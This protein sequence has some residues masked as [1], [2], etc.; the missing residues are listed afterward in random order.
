LTKRF[1]K[2]EHCDAN[3]A[4]ILTTGKGKNTTMELVGKA[5]LRSDISKYSGTKRGVERWIKIVE[6]A[7]WSHIEE[8]KKT[9]PSLISKA[10]ITESLQRLI[11]LLSEFT[12][13][14]FCLMQNIPSANYRIV[15]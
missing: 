4:K 5:K 7:E 15:N 8:V 13:S 11:T 3:L 2:C 9:L 1:S 10:M 12:T 6:G 14:F